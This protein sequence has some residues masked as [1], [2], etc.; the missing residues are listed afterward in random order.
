MEHKNG[1]PSKWEYNEGDKSLDGSVIERIIGREEDFILFLCDDGE[2]SWEHRDVPEWSYIGVEQYQ[3]L[4]REMHTLQGK[5]HRKQIL[6]YMAE[7]LLTVFRSRKHDQETILGY[8]KCAWD[9]I[10]SYKARKLLF[11]SSSFY[12]YEERDNLALENPSNEQNV[13]KL[14]IDAS[15]LSQRAKKN[16]LED[17]AKNANIVIANSF[18]DIE[19]IE[20]QDLLT[21]A[22]NLVESQIDEKARIEYIEKSIIASL[23]GVIALIITY[24]CVDSIPEEIRSILICSIAGIAGAFVSTLERGKTIK[25]DANATNQTLILQGVTRVVLGV[26]FGAL[27][28]ICANANIALGLASDNS[29]AI[30]VVAF[31]AGLNERFIPDLMKKNIN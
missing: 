6:S 4:G 27:V 31:L 13:Q 11:A 5:I 16:L 29:Y 25:V 1:Q 8:F 12:I 7:A 15:L 18:V 2:L 3:K 24:L 21:K 10:D 14:F 26:I 9:F 23:I 22:K 28:P 30:F 20:S 19:Q 17:A